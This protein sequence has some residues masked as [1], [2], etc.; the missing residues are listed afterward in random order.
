LPYP[1]IKKVGLIGFMFFQLVSIYSCF[2]TDQRLVDG[3]EF[4][5]ER[6]IGI[7]EGKSTTADVRELIGPPLVEKEEGKKIRWQYY[8]RKEKKEL[9]FGIIPNSTFVTET[10]LDVV[11]ENSIVQSVNRKAESFRE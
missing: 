7:Q 4:H 6:V 8:M 5:A 11:F 1:L 9:I 2:N 3:K 10:S